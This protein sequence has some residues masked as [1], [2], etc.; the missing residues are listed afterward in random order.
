[1][2]R[3]DRC[4]ESWVRA[5]GTGIPVSSSASMIGV[6]IRAS[7]AVGL[8]SLMACATPTARRD[9]DQ[10]RTDAPVPSPNAMV[11]TPDGVE[12][13]QV[14]LVP[15]GR[16]FAGIAATIGTPSIYAEEAAVDD[17]DPTMAAPD[18][19]ASSVA[20]ASSEDAAAG[21]ESIEVAIARGD[22]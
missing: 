5:W 2:S 9:G 13:G 12:D 16:D 11:E 10:V 20:T 18:A 21:E 1:M 3:F 4:D 14:A 6:C 15:P 7:A 19:G 8:V 22:A 17:V